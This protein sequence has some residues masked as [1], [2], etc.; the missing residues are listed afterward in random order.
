MWQINTSKGTQ[1]LA[2]HLCFTIP[3]KERR[4]PE[5][6]RARHEV[7]S[8]T[9]PVSGATR[10]S[11]QVP[12][13]PH[14]VMAPPESTDTEREGSAHKRSK[15]TA[16]RARSKGSKTA[17][18]AKEKASRLSEKAK[19]QL[20]GQAEQQKEQASEQLEDIGSAL[21]ETSNTLHERDKDSIANVMEGAAH[22][23]E[24]LSGYLRNHSVNDMLSQAERVARREPE[25]FLGGAAL[26]GLI[27]ARFFKSSSPDHRSHRRR[28]LPPETS[29][30]RYRA[31]SERRYRE[32]GRRYRETSGRG[33]RRSP[34]SERIRSERPQ[35][36]RTETRRPE[37][38]EE[39]RSTEKSR[40]GPKSGSGSSG[41]ESS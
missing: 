20:S 17:E 25:M 8:H 31:T 19:H 27:G 26:L 3:G 16:E 5:P 7:E 39:R 2:V 12:L 36:A 32:S 11:L 18:Q 41:S 14:R 10:S 40:S 9:G 15:K 30:R 21:R 22:Q 4:L 34:R 13:Q 35:P 28:Q 38:H 1:F 37:T 6:L 24:R 23:V 29:G 33:H